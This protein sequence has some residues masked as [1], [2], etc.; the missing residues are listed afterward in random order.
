MLANAHLHDAKPVVI[1]C[2]HCAQRL[3][4]IK[5][6]QW[7]AAKLEFTFECA[8]CGT[9]LSKTVAGEEPVA[10]YTSHAS[11]FLQKL[12]IFTLSS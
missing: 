2:P 12:E 7:A 1:V 10:A 3:M 9:E 4:E 6:V 5:D 11:A 8:D